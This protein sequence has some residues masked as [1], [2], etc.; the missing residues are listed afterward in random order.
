MYRSWLSWFRKT[1]C[2]WLKVPLPESCPDNLTEKPSVSKVP[3]AKFSAVD[4]SIFFPSFIAWYLKSNIFLRVLWI[5]KLLGTVEIFFPIFVKSVLSTPLS[6]L[7]SFPRPGLN[8][9]HAPS[10]HF[11]SDL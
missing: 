2:L 10:N 6:P 9:D 8:L 5:L 11:N 4:Q 7:L 3:K 1:A